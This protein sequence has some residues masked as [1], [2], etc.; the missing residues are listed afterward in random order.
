MARAA[1][2][3]VVLGHE[4]DR[5]SLLGGDLL[6]GVLVDH[7]VVRGLE[8]LGVEEPDL[9]LAEVA[10]ALGALDVEPGV[11]HVGADRAQQRLGPAGAEDRVVDVVLVDRR[12]VVPAGVGGVLV[13]GVEGDELQLGAGE[14]LPAV[15]GAA[16]ELAAQDPARRLGDGGVVGPLEV[17]LHERSSGQVGE[18]PGG[19]L[20]EHELHVAVPALPRRDRVPVDGV[21]VDIDGEQVVAALG[22]VSDH[23]VG[24]V[25]AVQPLALQ[26]A[27]HVGE[28]DDDRVDRAVVDATQQ[29][30][31][32]EMA[33]VAQVGH[34]GPIPRGHAAARPCRRS[35]AP[36]P[37]AHGRAVRRGSPGR[38]RRAAGRS[39]RCS[40][41]APGWRAASR[42]ASPAP[43]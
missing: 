31:H 22:A 37:A 6:G 30:L 9:V 35:A 26:P 25:A 10:L 15:L 8:R 4:G 19:A 5:L 21:H 28:P 11:E 42:A 43:T 18:Q 23:V 33:V 2:A 39:G 3:L 1:L 29:V 7:V 38:R 12:E 17:A 34:V 41:R 40:R 27:L 24:E 16:V 20:V 36:S 13:A 32:R 14:G